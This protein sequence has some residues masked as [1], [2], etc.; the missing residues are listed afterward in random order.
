MKKILLTLGFIVSAQAFNADCTITE[1]GVAKPLKENVQ[2]TVKKDK[3]L[4]FLREEEYSYMLLEKNNNSLTYATPSGII[5]LKNIKDGVLTYEE[6][7]Y[8]DG[9][10][11]KCSIK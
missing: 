7:V 10:S 3:L 1:W 5:I 9:F 11:G 6:R 8:G 4:F 2:I